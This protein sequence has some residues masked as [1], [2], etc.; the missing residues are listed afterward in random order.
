[1]GTKRIA[2]TGDGVITT[3]AIVH[4]Q[5]KDPKKVNAERDTVTTNR[6]VRCVNAKGFMLVL[7]S[8]IGEEKWSQAFDRLLNDLEE[9]VL[10]YFVSPFGLPQPVDSFD[11]LC[12]KVVG[13][14]VHLNLLDAE[15]FITTFKGGYPNFEGFARGPRT[16][17]ANV[18]GGS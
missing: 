12:Q 14:L 7:C 8:L 11:G 9:L 1:M 17:G 5:M 4:A 15:I 2:A 6:C 16:D 10:V 3:A 13:L 18:G